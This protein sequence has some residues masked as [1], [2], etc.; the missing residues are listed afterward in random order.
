MKL[1]SFF[2]CA[3]LA[4]LASAAPGPPAALIDAMHTPAQAKYPHYESYPDSKAHH[5]ARGY[6][7]THM[8]VDEGAAAAHNWKN[9]NPSTH[10]TA[11]GYWWNFAHP[12]ATKDDSLHQECNCVPGFHAA[13]D[14]K[15]HVDAF[16]H[17]RVTHPEMACSGE[18][19]RADKHRWH[20][21]AP[22]SPDSGEGPLGNEAGKP[23]RCLK[24]HWTGTH[25]VAWA[26]LR[27]LVGQPC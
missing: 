8:W 4:A 14:V 7:R 9:G 12:N 20:Y 2:A 11:M 16:G 18:Q 23:D 15:C 26:T 19:Y 13:L 21:K 27:S 17:L 10:H 24:R 5:D 22:N 25:G 6:G 3:T 1:S